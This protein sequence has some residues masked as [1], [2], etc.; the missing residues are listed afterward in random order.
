M[1]EREKERERKRIFALSTRVK[2]AV[3]LYSLLVHVVAIQ[4]DALRD[5]RVEV[6]SQDIWGGRNMLSSGC[7]VVA[8]PTLGG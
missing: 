4:I 3:P 1:R 2:P 6:G 5:H 8:M 7:R